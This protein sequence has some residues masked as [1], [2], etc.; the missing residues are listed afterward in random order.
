M[1][2]RTILIALLS[3][4]ASCFAE[5]AMPEDSVLHEVITKKAG[6]WMTHDLASFGVDNAY[7]QNHNGEQYVIVEYTGTFNLKPEY[8]RSSTFQGSPKVMNK[9]GSVSVVK[10]GR[11]WYY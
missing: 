6:M 9:S 4:P 2:F 8:H 3:F 1:I 11:N 5:V 10:R 7:T